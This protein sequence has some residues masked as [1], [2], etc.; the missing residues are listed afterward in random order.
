MDW[1]DFALSQ[2]LNFHPSFVQNRIVEK[3]DKE[4]EIYSGGQEPQYDDGLYMKNMLF[5]NEKSGTNN[6]MDVS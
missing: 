2:V 4:K 1:T 6:S 5:D 3:K